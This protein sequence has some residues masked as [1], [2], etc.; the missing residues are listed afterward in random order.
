MRRWLVERFFA[1]I[2]WQ[3]RI[4]I[5]WEY[6]AH[7]FLGFVQLPASLSSSNNFEMGSGQATLSRID[8]GP[9]SYSARVGPFASEKDAAA[10]CG[11]RPRHG[12]SG[13]K[14]SYSSQIS[15]TLFSEDCRFVERHLYDRHCAAHPTSALSRRQRSHTQIRI[16]VPF[17]RSLALCIRLY[18]LRT[19]HCLLRSRA[20]SDFQETAL[21]MTPTAELLMTLPSL[22][23]TIKKV[24]P[25]R[26][27]LLI[28]MAQL[29]R[30]GQILYTSALS[31][32]LRAV[33]S[34]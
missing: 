24:V 27:F 28:T 12:V 9:Q 11:R 31:E 8:L 10:A 29:N 6:H 14:A 7:N 4:L 26:V 25:S 13:P 18:Q 23:E 2:Q 16:T 5:R 1:W 32:R 15:E 21:P 34:P 30:S 17:H 3:R 33:L 22:G 20:S 19:I